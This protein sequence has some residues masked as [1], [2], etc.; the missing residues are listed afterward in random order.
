MQVKECIKVLANT[1][2]NITNAEKLELSYEYQE[3][4]QHLCLLFILTL[5][6]HPIQYV[7]FVIRAVMVDQH[8]KGLQP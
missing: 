5:H 8:V 6:T 3:H 2:L 4:L 1:K 7:T